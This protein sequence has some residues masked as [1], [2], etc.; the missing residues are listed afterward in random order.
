MM[1]LHLL[2]DE[3]ESTFINLP[4]NALRISFRSPIAVVRQV[5]SDIGN[6][7]CMVDV[8]GNSDIFPARA[9]SVARTQTG[10][11]GLLDREESDRAS[12]ID[13]RRESLPLMPRESF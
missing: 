9:K 6:H 5:L 13:E 12:M 4:P 8:E 11:K 2:D 1:H 3:R 7:L 10:L